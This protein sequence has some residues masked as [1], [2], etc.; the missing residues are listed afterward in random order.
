MLILWNKPILG[1]H[2]FHLSIVTLFTNTYFRLKRVEHAH[3]LDKICFCSWLLLVGYARSALKSFKYTGCDTQWRFDLSLCGSICWNRYM[4]TTLYMQNWWIS[5][6]VCFDLFVPRLLLIDVSVH[7][8]QPDVVEGSIS[9]SLEWTVMLS[10]TSWYT[11]VLKGAQKYLSPF[12]FPLYALWVCVWRECSIFNK[13][14]NREHFVLL[15]GPW[16]GY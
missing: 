5:Q 11:G 7:V 4:Y 2:C 1:F 10:S 14:S 16:P 15:L 6:R 13:C 12:L 8:M 3:G 9:G